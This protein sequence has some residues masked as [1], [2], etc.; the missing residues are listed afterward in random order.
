M[1][2]KAATPISEALKSQHKTKLKIIGMVTEKREA[3]QQQLITIE[4]L[5]ASATILVPTK[6]SEE[7]QRKAQV[8][9]PDQIICAAVVKTRSHLFLAED[10][11]FPEVG[12]KP[13]R[14]HQNHF[15][16]CSPQTFMWEATNSTR[17]PSNAS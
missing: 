3:K 16:P 2:L 8:L 6:A 5:N 10:I 15:T 12:Q 1:D 11:I 9:L 7:V 13:M 4:D 14:R 17:K